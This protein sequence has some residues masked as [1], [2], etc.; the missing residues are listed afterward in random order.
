MRAETFK[1]ILV[2]KLGT[3]IN[4][5]PPELAVL[6]SARKGI[7]AKSWSDDAVYTNEENSPRFEIPAVVV[8]TMRLVNAEH[9][10]SR[11]L[12]VYWLL[13][14]TA[15]QQGIHRERHSI[16]YSAVAKYL[17]TRNLQRVRDALD[18]L[19][20]TDVRYDCNQDG[21]RNQGAKLIDIAEF[22][23]NQ[24]FN[25]RTE[26]YFSLPAVLRRAVQ[27][28]KDYA[29]VD[30]NALS[31]LKSRYAITLYI[32]LCYLSG[33]YDVSRHV[34]ELGTEKMADILSFP[35]KRY[36]KANLMA[37]VRQ[38]IEEIKGLSKLHR[39]FD[40]D[41][42]EPN[43]FTEQYQISVGSSSKR[44]AEAAPAEL[45]AEEYEVV[46]ARNVLPLE[47]HHY[48]SVLRLR[49]AA[50]V[51]GHSTRI[52]SHEWRTDVWG[53]THYGADVAGMEAED[54]LRELRYGNLEKVFD[55]WVSRLTFLPNGLRDKKVVP[56][57]IMAEP[58]AKVATVR[59]PIED[60]AVEPEFVPE[61][62]TRVGEELGVFEYG[63]PEAP[64]LVEAQDIDDCDIPF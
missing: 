63:E 40:L 3:Y 7:A 17:G 45:S 43:E 27:K 24:P 28:S 53:A 29:M 36:R 44:V 61:D 54:F 41:C 10:A 59:E 48:P 34:W 2:T 51:V 22:D 8:R 42:S 31:R 25:G 4:K 60:R 11:D 58:V 62:D 33:M 21:T 16:T 1:S 32:R 30:I 49:Q 19:N 9:L 46:Y 64:K 47:A 38:A 20:I 18:R 15:R 5:R 13:F 52:V 50:T 14:A 26:I 39:R 6:G 55:W 23:P 57:F 35:R 37:A 56:A 12:A